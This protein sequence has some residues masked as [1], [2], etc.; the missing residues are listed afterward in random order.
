M[1]II[2]IEALE[3]GQHP[4][5]SQSHRTECWLEGWIEVPMH[6]ES[7]VWETRGWC[8]LTIEDGKLTGITPTERPEPEPQ[9]TPEPTQLDRVE[10][11]AT[12]TA[13]MTDTLLPEEV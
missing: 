1:T 10:A 4:I 3:S 11:Q 5:Q 6:L 9:P 2:K 12:Y 8:D 13:M 7:A